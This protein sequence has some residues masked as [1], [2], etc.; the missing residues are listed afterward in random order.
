MGRNCAIARATPLTLVALLAEGV[1]RN[2]TPTVTQQP[3][4]TVALLTEGVDKHTG[5]FGTVGDPLGGLNLRKEPERMRIFVI[6]YFV[7]GLIFIKHIK[8]IL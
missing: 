3:R 4:G 6:T 8:Y 7:Y 5:D 2:L 1:G